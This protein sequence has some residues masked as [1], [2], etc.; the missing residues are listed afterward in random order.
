MEVAD[1]QFKV[2]KFALQCGITRVVNIHWG[3]KVSNYQGWHGKSHGQWAEYRQ[4]RA[5]VLKQVVRWAQELD[6]DGLLQDTV[7]FCYS[8][9]GHSNLHD[10][11]RIPFFLI[12]GGLGN[13]RALDYRGTNTAKNPRGESECHTKLLVSLARWM[14]DASKSQQGYTGH[15]TGPLPDFPI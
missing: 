5:P 3:H 14:G 6:K 7:V 1:E 8:E 10:H 15:G 11:D 13:G 4:V 12:G 9:I 2:A